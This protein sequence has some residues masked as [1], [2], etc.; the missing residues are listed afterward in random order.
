[1]AFFAIDHQSHGTGLP[2]VRL[3]IL[4]AGRFSNEITRQQAAVQKIDDSTPGCK[5]LP[6]FVLA[7]YAGTVQ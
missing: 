1:M 7:I 2:L 5:K 4:I 6:F 3:L